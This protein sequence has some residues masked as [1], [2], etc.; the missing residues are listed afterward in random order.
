MLRG[1]APDAYLSIY[2]AAVAMKCRSQAP[3]A[4]P[5]LDRKALKSFSEAC[6]GH[7]VE[8]LV[9]FVC[10]CLYTYVEELAVE[11]KSDIEWVQ[12]FKPDSDSQELFFLNRPIDEAGELLNLNTFLHRYDKVSD[13]GHRLQ[14]RENFSDWC[15]RWPS[16]DYPCGRKILCCPEDS[17]RFFSGL[18]LADTQQEV[19]INHSQNISQ[20]PASKTYIA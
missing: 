16:N 10:A 6:K 8:S 11:G 1:N 4:G 19:A 15:L 18:P 17:R 12:P 20:R 2:N 13:A 5:S 3:I 9:C 7:K 14:D